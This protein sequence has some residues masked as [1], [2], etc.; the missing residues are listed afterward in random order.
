MAHISTRWVQ[1]CSAEGPENHEKVEQKINNA[2]LSV[3]LVFSFNLCRIL[4]KERAKTFFIAIISH[5]FHPG[6]KRLEKKIRDMAD[7]S[8][9]GVTLVISEPCRVHH[10]LIL[11]V[12]R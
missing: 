5:I 9:L 6:G 2:C 12:K 7:F 1:V 4:L 8:S 10:C 11:I 3:G